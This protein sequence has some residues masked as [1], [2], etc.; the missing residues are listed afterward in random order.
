MAKQL[1]RLA[2]RSFPAAF[3]AYMIALFSNRPPSRRQKHIATGTP[4]REARYVG[5]TML[6]LTPPTGTTLLISVILAAVAVAG[7]YIHQ[8]SNYVPISMFWLAI[9]AY[10]I[11]L[12]GN[13]I[14]GV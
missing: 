7:Q 13:L 2:I 3:A 9:I 12:L 1:I 6:R 11:L 14:R 8:I 4:P 10:I 5:D